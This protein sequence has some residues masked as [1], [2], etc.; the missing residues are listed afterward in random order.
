MSLP[1]Y[2]KKTLLWEY[3]SLFCCPNS[4]LAKSQ[5]FQ[6][7]WKSF[8]TKAEDVLGTAL[9]WNASTSSSTAQSLHDELKSISSHPCPYSNRKRNDLSNTRVWHLTWSYALK[10]QPCCKKSRWWAGCRRWERLTKYF[11]ESQSGILFLRDRFKIK[12]LLACHQH[13]RNTQKL[14]SVDRT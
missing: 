8:G 6:E 11:S 14:T 9:S 10:F 4:L 5:K 12:I 13:C 3:F 1:A 2:R 7:R